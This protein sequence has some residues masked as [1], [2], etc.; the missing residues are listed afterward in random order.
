MCMKIMSHDII[1]NCL[2]CNQ[3][4]PILAY[5]QLGVIFRGSRMENIV[6]ACL[7]FVVFSTGNM[8]SYTVK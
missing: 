2:K 4:N 1:S 8:S 6:R 3:G 5:M 7:N